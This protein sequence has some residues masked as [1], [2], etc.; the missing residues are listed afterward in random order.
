[1]QASAFSVYQGG[2]VKIVSS[3]L[4]SHFGEDFCIEEVG[5]KLTPEKKLRR[6]TLHSYFNDVA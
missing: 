3:Y 2:I 6:Q 4:E 1:M 5:M